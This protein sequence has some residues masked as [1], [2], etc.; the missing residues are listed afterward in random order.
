MNGSVALGLHNF[1][2]DYNQT[3]IKPYATAYLNR[4]TYKICIL[5]R[6]WIAS[7]PLV[8]WRLDSLNP[9]VYCSKT[10]PSIGKAYSDSRQ[11]NSRQNDINLKT[12]ADFFA[13]RCAKGKFYN[14][15]PTP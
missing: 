14:I 9:F 4:I 11:P 7:C 1:N 6:D 3:P 10:R 5:S 13:A 2:D 12:A 15:A 8:V